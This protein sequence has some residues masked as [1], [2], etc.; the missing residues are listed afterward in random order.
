MADN[1]NNA[2]ATQDKCVSKVKT[3]VDF[4]TH[5]NQLKNILA[6]LDNTS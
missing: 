2:E 4:K 1:R 6:Q 5:L 3:I